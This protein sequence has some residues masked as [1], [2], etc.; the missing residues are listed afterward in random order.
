MKAAWYDRYGPADVLEIRDV[1]RPEPKDDEIL[2]QIFATSVTTA[3]WRFRASKFP[4][5]FWLAGRAMAGLFGPRKNVLGSEFAGRVVARGKAVT[6]FKGGDEVFGFSTGL[7]ANA[8]Y[9]SVSEDSPVVKKPATV[10]YDEA[11]ATPFGGQ[12]ALAFLRDF[13]QVQPSRKVLIAGASGGVGVWAVQIAK[14]LGAE[15]SAVT[16]TRNVDLVRSLGAD[17]VIDYT[18]ADFAASDECYDLIFD[19]A[20]TTDFD[21]AKHVLKPNGV[22]LPLE[23]GGREIGQALLSKI[24]GGKRVIVGVSSDSREMLEYLAGLLET[25]EIRAVI[26]SQYPLEEIADAHRRV[27]SRHKRGSVIVT[28]SPRALEVAKAA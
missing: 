28:I 11:A 3:D 9:I 23:F 21:Q 19:T 8:E 6:R 16:S 5:I 18:K 15:V 2:V 10:G 27:E 4:T 17:H 24:T 12:S 13:A 1:P 25:G 20:G 14:H 7:G 22:F 26:D